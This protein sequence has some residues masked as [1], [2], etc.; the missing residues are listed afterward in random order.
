M[1]GSSLL[2]LTKHSSEASK[3][4][5]QVLKC[6]SDLSASLQIVS[7]QIQ[8]F[9]HINRA[10]QARWEEKCCPNTMGKNL[11]YLLFFSS[12]STI[13]L[14]CLKGLAVYASQLVH[15][16]W[17]YPPSGIGDST[18]LYSEA[19]FESRVK[20][21]VYIRREKPLLPAFGDKLFFFQCIHNVHCTIKKMLKLICY[22]QWVRLHTTM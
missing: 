6:E 16:L 11:V 17:K 1:S 4:C 3:R 19:W 12:S 9:S 2:F 13:I 21:E 7:C 20:Y 15:T 18:Y 5:I 22:S 14:G 10:S 8:L